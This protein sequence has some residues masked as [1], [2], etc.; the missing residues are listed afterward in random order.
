MEIGVLNGE[1]AKTM[2]DVAVQNVSPVEVEY[3]GFDFFNGSG[4]HHVGQKLERTGCKFRF[5]K[6]DTTVTLPK[7]VKILPKMDLIFIDGGK[8]YTEAKS[9]W[10]Y[11]KTLMHDETA[12]FIHNYCFSGVKRMVDEISRDSYQVKIIHPLNDSDTA[13]VK[14]KTQMQKTLDEG[15]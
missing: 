11:S 2:V 6:G 9:D 7:A 15:T 10:E 4:S 14:K 13:L 3:Y 8:S 1:N 5:F 12:V